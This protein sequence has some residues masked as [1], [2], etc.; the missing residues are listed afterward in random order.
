MQTL[1]YFARHATYKS[2]SFQQRFLPTGFRDFCWNERAKLNCNLQTCC[3]SHVVN[4]ICPKDDRRQLANHS[5]LVN[6]TLPAETETSSRVEPRAMMASWQGLACA[7]LPLAPLQHQGPVYTGHK[8]PKQKNTLWLTRAFIQ[9]SSSCLQTTSKD[10]H[11]HLCELALSRIFGTEGFPF[12]SKSQVGF[13]E[14]L[15]REGVPEERRAQGRERA[16]QTITHQSQLELTLAILWWGGARLGPPLGFRWGN[17]RYTRF[18][19]GTYIG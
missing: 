9:L 8:A 11:V 7:E 12:Q 19:F 4:A 3:R 15:S 14:I 10:L 2:V 6:G 16:G 18:S 1:R 13:S 17:F 5:L